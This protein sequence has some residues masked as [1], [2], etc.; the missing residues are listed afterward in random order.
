MW[1]GKCPFGAEEVESQCGPGCKAHWDLCHDGERS[2][3]LGVQVPRHH[4]GPS[5]WERVRDQQV[6]TQCLKGWWH[7]GRRG[8]LGDMMGEKSKCLGQSESSSPTKDQ[9]A[10]PGK[11]ELDQT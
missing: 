6:K 1:A 5:G 2:Q 3:H 11:G 10:T 8:P 7:K 9:A 4:A